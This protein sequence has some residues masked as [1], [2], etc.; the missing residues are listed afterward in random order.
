MSHLARTVVALVAAAL[1]VPLALAAPA[2]AA[3]APQVRFTETD[4]VLGDRVRAIVDP[5]SRPRGTDL[6]LQ[7][8]FPD[9]WRTA[10]A[11]AERTRHGF[12]LQVPTDQLGSFLFRVVAKDG[13]R[14][15]AASTRRTV[16]VRPDHD[17]VGR[18]GQHNRFFSGAGDPIRWDSCRRIRWTYN[19]QNAPTRG[20]KQVRAGFKRIH[21]ATGLEFEYAGTTRQKPNPFGRR[22]RNAD[23]IIGWRTAADY[24]PFRANP[25]TVGV[26]GNR[27]QEGYQEPDGFRVAQAVSGGV[28]LNASQDASLDNGY[29]PGFT[30]GE[31]IIHELGHVVGLNHADADSQIMY[32]QTIPRNAE[33]GAGDLTGLEKVG[34]TRGCLTR[35]AARTLDRL[36]S[37]SAY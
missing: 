32:F 10:D 2:S 14:T 20:R 19:P 31:V 35:A 18:P 36:G 33:W 8:R 27:Y 23:I 9:G 1:T 34:D 29:G 37:V 7:R 6:V 28:V 13:R 11:T 21:Q 12:V 5:D 4:A 22:V 17:P 16:R 25:N 15:V 24:P 3:R 26:G 30:W